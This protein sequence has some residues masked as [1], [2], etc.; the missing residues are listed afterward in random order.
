MKNKLT[1]NEQTL[2]QEREIE[3]KKE[4][5]EERKKYR[6]EEKRKEEREGKESET[7][8]QWQYIRFG[9]LEKK[10]VALL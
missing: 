4:R 10:V 1:A 9:G 3:R 8:V 2:V 6:K 7:I 5:K